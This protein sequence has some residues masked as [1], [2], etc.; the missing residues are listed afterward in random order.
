[1]KNDEDQMNQYKYSTYS[2][3]DDKN[4]TEHTFSTSDILNQAKTSEIR[5]AILG[6]VFTYI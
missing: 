6:N 2:V 3:E 1:M 4:I 5:L